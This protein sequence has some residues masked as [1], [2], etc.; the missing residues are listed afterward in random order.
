M[1]QSQQQLYLKDSQTLEFE[2][3]VIEALLLPDDRSA[4]ILDHSYFYP[5][6]GGQEH[7]TG[8]LNQMRVI[9]VYKDDET[10][11]ILHVIDRPLPLGPATGKIDA[12]RRQRHMQHHTAQ[13][14]LTQCFVHLFALD[15]LSAH[16]NGYAPSTLDLPIEYLS[17]EKLTQA[18]NLANQVIYENRPVH[19]YFVTPEDL[20]NLPLR[21][22]PK[23]SEDIR[24]VEIDGFDTTPCGGTHCSSTGQI[25]LIKIIK[26][27]KQ[28]ERL[29]VHFV[30]G[31]QALAIFQ[32]SFDILSGLAGQ[33][34]IAAQDLPEMVVRQSEQLQLAQKELQA[35]RL[36]RIGWE[37]ARLAEGAERLL[38]RQVVL[39]VFNA[40]PVND[41][42]TLGT[43]LGKQTGLIS[44][45]ASVDGSK[46]TL[47]VACSEGSGLAARDLLV[48][49]LAPF[50][51]RGGGDNKL[52]QGGGSVP[53]DQI[54]NLRELLNNCLLSL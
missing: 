18:E 42:R 45:L 36:E 5:T 6:G 35:L 14:L 23:V 46:L 19:S 38:E 16:I 28:N 12:E 33:L 10:A 47:L 4:V 44:V 51:G 31:W 25:G 29:R 1:P 30:A 2:T 27:E 49:L 39:A 53:P 37:A 34:S 7:D 54:E 26:T 20:E 11:R 17:K 8:F 52:A 43:E 21:R 50:N 41:L 40:R 13:H 24:I 15:T 9:D 32:F 3:T 22:A 48:K